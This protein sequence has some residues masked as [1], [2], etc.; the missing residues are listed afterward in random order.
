MYPFLVIIMRFCMFVNGILLRTISPNVSTIILSP[1]CFTFPSPFFAVVCLVAVQGS[2][3]LFTHLPDGV[4]P[5]PSLPP[6]TSFAIIALSFPFVR[7]LLH[8]VSLRFIGACLCPDLPLPFSLPAVQ[9]VRNFSFRKRRRLPPRRLA[10]I[11]VRILVSL[12][13]LI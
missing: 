12:P 3:T 10:H 11:G 8:F 2:H 7:P 5:F 6:G 9:L 4:I 1:R 13:P